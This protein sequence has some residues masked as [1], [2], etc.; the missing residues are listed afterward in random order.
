MNRLRI[1]INGFGRIGRAI[2]RINFKR[3]LFDI[4]A[5]ND[6]NPDNHNIAYLLQYDS[7]YGKF[8][9]KVSD[10]N[11]SLKIDGKIIAVH[12]AKLISE[13]PWEDY[14]VDVVIESS[15]VEKNLPEMDKLVP[16]MK[17]VITTYDAGDNAQT[18][19]FGCNE[20]KLSPKKNFLLSASICDA[21]ALAPIVKLIERGYPI[22]SGYL[23][24]LHAWLSYQNLLDGPSASWS[25]PGDIFSHYALGRSSPMN[26]IPKSTSAVIAT[27]KVIPEITN[28]IKSFSFRV[29]TNIVSGAT[30]IL[31]LKKDIERK[32]LIKKFKSFEKRQKQKIIKNSTEPL[33]SIDYIGEEYSAIID[34]RWT[35][36]N[37][38]RLVKL[39]Y[40]Y[41]NEWGYSSRVIDLIA[42]LKKYY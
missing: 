32:N 25:Q 20:R 10:T 30:L 27:E 7:T 38:K 28:K 9:K 16:K 33:T 23:A 31:Y 29:P 15:G 39:V 13:V 41:D 42:A 34:H 37:K 19:I 22:R 18:I 24:T 35:Q 11:N 1:G 17:N 5:I 40:W 2:Y 12:H 26:I 36:V 8:P 4:V 21:T 3:K 14:G 6:I